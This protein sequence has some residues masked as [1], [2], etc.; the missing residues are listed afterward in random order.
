M[1]LFLSKIA[2]Q[3][4]ED[5]KKL[6]GK[7]AKEICHQRRHTQGD[8]VECGVWRGGSAMLAALTLIQ[9]N[10]T[11]WKIYLYDTYEGMSEPI[12]KDIDIHGATYRA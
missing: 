8:I 1:G 6:T 12:D 5:A 3:F 4:E 9:N 7:L 11:H 10:Q 2:K